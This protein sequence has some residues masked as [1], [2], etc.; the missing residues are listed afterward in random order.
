[1]TDD[2]TKMLAEM[3]LDVKAMKSELKELRAIVSG[4]PN[5]SEGWLDTVAAAQALK[6]EGIRSPKHLRQLRLDGIFSEARNEIR[7]VSKGE[8]R[9]TWQFHVPL[10]RKR[11]QRYFKSLPG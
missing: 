10:C 1:M 4:S 6:N 8:G 7:N 9:S 2:T 5:Y 3:F 11:L